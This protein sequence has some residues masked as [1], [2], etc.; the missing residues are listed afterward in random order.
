MYLEEDPDEF[1]PEVA[2]LKEIGFESVRWVCEILKE[3]LTWELNA[4]FTESSGDSAADNQM[5]WTNLR[6][7]RRERNRPFSIHISLS[8]DYIWPLLI[9]E[10]SQAEKAACS[11]TLASTIVHELCVRR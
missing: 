10:Y 3:C 9:E 1:Y 7:S 8:V 2:R 11:F 6:C 5:A 4:K